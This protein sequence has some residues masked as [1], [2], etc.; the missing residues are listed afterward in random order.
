VGSSLPI[1]ISIENKK[2]DGEAVEDGWITED[3]GEVRMRK[4]YNTLT[5]SLL[6]INCFSF[7]QYKIKL[8]VNAATSFKLQCSS[9]AYLRFYR[10]LFIES[11]T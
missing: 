8:E 4:E 7:T 10:V 1:H 11:S 5:F 3:I 2:G 9:S 6:T